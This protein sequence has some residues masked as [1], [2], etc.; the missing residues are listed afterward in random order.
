VEILSPGLAAFPLSCRT[1]VGLDA[2]FDWLQERLAARLD[3]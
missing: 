2:W 3:T 1:G